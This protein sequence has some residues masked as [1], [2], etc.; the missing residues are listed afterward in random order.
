M[1]TIVLNSTMKNAPNERHPDQR[2][3]IQA[4]DGLARVQPNPVE[5]VDRFG[6]DRAAADHLPE[7]EPEQR[8]DRNHRVAKHV[9]DAHLTLGE[10]LARAVRT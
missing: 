8:D 1:S 4:A 9:A 5:V 6:E 2:R 3:Q 10:P 7:V